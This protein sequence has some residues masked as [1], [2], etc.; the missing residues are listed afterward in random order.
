[1]SPPAPFDAPTP[2]I[3]PSPFAAVRPLIEPPS[4]PFDRSDGTAAAGALLSIPPQEASLC[5]M[6]RRLSSTSINSERHRRERYNSWQK[7]CVFCVLCVCGIGEGLLMRQPLHHRRP[8]FPAVR[9]QGCPTK[10]GS[11][12]SASRGV[13]RWPR[14]AVGSSQ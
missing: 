4:V 6:S 11:L 12:L 10:S 9:K 3:N 2:T 8:S 13:N 14:W 1:M 5:T 7:R